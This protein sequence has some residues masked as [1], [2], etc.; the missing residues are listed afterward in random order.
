MRDDPWS[1]R[2]RVVTESLNWQHCAPFDPP[3]EMKPLVATMR[4]VNDEPS[5]GNAKDG[6]RAP[7]CSPLESS[8]TPLF[9]N[10]A[11]DSGF[12]I[13]VSHRGVASEATGNIAPKTTA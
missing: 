12:P 10:P 7:V 3:S 11:G 6:P 1:K 9:K 5:H 13:L 8:V 4:E 2:F